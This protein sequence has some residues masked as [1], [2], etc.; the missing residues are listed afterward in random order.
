MRERPDR[1]VILREAESVDAQVT[2]F[3]AGM[4]DRYAL[5]FHAE[6]YTPKPWMSLV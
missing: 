1:Y 5:A 3:V 4:T 2:D 6:V